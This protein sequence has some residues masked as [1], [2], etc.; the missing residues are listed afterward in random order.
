MIK[1]FIDTFFGTPR[2]IL[3]VFAEALESIHVD[4]ASVLTFVL[5]ALATGTQRTSISLFSE[6]VFLSRKLAINR[7]TADSSH[8]RNHSQ[9]FSEDLQARRTICSHRVVVTIY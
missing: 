6:T 2:S 8:R 5:K 3:F 7:L 1:F 4:L 9:S